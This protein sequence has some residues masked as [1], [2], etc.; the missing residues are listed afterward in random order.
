MKMKRQASAKSK[1]LFRAASNRIQ[2][3]LAHVKETVVWWWRRS[4][5]QIVSHIKE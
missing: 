1:V 5:V 3:N 2:R 4:S